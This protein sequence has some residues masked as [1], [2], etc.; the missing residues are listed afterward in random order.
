VPEEG[1][2]NGAVFFGAGEKGGRGMLV[3]RDCRLDRLPIQQVFTWEMFLREKWALST[4]KAFEIFRY[5]YRSYA[6]L[7]EDAQ[8]ARSLE[9]LYRSL[10]PF[11]AG[12]GQHLS[13]PLFEVP[14]TG[15]DF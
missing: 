5:V 15:G 14:R 13:D 11:S 8:R 4:Q 1:P 7:A 6:E 2:R 10:T 9:G 3:R 12:G